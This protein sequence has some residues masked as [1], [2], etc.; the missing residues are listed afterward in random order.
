M[1]DVNTVCVWDFDD[2]ERALGSA[3]NGDGMHRVYLLQSIRVQRPVHL[4]V[5]AGR[6]VELHGLCLGTSSA[7]PPFVRS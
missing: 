3:G 1:C 5:R 7:L 2:L 6:T 4:G